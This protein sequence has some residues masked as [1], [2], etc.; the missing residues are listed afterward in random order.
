MLIGAWPLIGLLGWCVLVS[1]LFYLYG[2]PKS[3]PIGYLLS[4]AFALLIGPGTFVFLYLI[5]TGGTDHDQAA[6]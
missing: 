1:R 3:G 6:K 2:P 5:L 4:L